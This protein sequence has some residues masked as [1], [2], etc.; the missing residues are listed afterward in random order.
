MGYNSL[1]IS[2][3]IGEAGMSS[4]GVQGPGPETMEGEE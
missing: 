1:A 4:N 3:Q 2:N